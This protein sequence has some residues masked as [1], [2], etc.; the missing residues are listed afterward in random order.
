MMRARVAALRTAF[1]AADTG[2]ELVDSGA[3]FAYVRH[4]FAGRT[5]QWVAR[6]LADRHNLLCL[7]GSMFGPGQDA[8]LRLAF[9]NLES[10][11]IPALL[12][13]LQASEAAG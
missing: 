4:P 8:Y 13:R 1:A 7:P 2:Y 3:Y 11:S 12:E 10:A 9:A 6:M 5:A